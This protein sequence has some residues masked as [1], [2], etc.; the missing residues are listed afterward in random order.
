MQDMGGKLRFVPNFMFKTLQ[1]FAHYASDGLKHQ[2]M[3][4][5]RS[6]IFLTF[7]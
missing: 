6:L 1:R 3:R 5:I 4:G 7:E 2:V